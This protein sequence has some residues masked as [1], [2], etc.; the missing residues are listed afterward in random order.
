MS[1]GCLTTTRISILATSRCGTARSP[2]AADAYVAHAPVM[3][4]PT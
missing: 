2:N 1:I 3:P 4:T